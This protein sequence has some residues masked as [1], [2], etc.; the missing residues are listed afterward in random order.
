MIDLHSTV[1]EMLRLH[2]PRETIK[3]CLSQ[4]LHSDA[5]TFL[6]EVEDE[7]LVRHAARLSTHAS[8]RD[9]SSPSL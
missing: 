6:S 7:V 9:A 3:A 8:T 4:V 5:E 1:L 2:F